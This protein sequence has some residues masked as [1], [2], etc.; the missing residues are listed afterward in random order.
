MTA[1]KTAALAENI[2]KTVAAATKPAAKAAKPGKAA[3]APK[4]AAAVA[5]DDKPARQ[6]LLKSHPRPSLYG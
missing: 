6:K 3:A 4:A 2:T 5:D 1:K